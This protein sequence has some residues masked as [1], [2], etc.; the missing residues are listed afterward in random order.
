MSQLR[1]ALV[2]FLLL[3]LFTGGAYP[4]ITTL[5]GQ[6]WFPWQA[7][8][9]LLKSNDQL[10]GSALLGQ[11]FT[12][13]GYFHGRPSATAGMPYNPL[14][15]GGS[16]LAVSN[17]QTTA[18]IAARAAALHQQNPQ[19]AGTIPV[20][21]LTASGSGLDNGLSL[22]AVHWQLPRVAAARHLPVSAIMPLIERNTIHPWPA[23]IGETYVNVTLLNR[24]L[25]QLATP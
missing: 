11:N 19:A 13:A 15:S 21:L 1:P 6:W 17:P 5:L 9:S 14:A 12:S 18:A 20:D 16:N 4:L 24:D 3:T 22:Q 2:L 23:F 25:D 10:R 8:G 7:Q